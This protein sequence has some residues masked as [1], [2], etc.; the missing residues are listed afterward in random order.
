MYY[1]TTAQHTEHQLHQWA[2]SFFSKDKRNQSWPHAATV[3]QKEASFLHSCT[4]C[5]MQN[6]EPKH[7]M[8]LSGKILD[9]ASKIWQYPEKKHCPLSSETSVCNYCIVLKSFRC[10]HTE[11]LH[12]RLATYLDI[13]V[14]Y[15]NLCTAYCKIKTVVGWE[16]QGLKHPK[17]IRS[18]LKFSIRRI[19]YCLQVYTPFQNHLP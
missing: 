13:F 11:A 14:A 12:C 4:T 10:F 3:I 18:I 1:Y 8:F 6:G 19:V 7:W 2:T 15:S 16:V 5:S 17:E 9:K